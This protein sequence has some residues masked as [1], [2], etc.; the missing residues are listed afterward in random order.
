MTGLF[1]QRV[2]RATSGRP[3]LPRTVTPPQRGRKTPNT[4]DLLRDGVRA[5]RDPLTCDLRRRIV[6]TWRETEESFRLAKTAP[7]LRLT[8]ASIAQMRRQLCPWL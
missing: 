8:L 3:A 5:R 4:A 7:A 1:P 6:P 2:G